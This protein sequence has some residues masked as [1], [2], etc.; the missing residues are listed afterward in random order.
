MNAGCSKSWLILA[1]FFI[2]MI[3]TVCTSLTS[4]IND[5]L[6]MG[7]FVL[8]SKHPI[9]RRCLHILQSRL[10]VLSNYACLFNN[11]SNSRGV[12]NVY[13]QKIRKTLGKA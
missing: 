4:T 1:I 7:M 12:H 11:G 5:N 2:N 8:V 9:Q 13:L 10:S 3:V 6:K